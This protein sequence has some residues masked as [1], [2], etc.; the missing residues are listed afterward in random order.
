M[1][2]K[3][4][5]F[6]EK[7]NKKKI[8]KKSKITYIEELS[9]NIMD[10]SLDKTIVENNIL[11][12]LFCDEAVKLSRNM[13]LKQDFQLQRL[14]KILE[15]LDS[16]GVSGIEYKIS[17][18]LK[19]ELYKSIVNNH[20][21]T[22]GYWK[23]LFNRWQTMNA[24]PEYTH[25]GNIDRIID[26][27]MTD[28]N[29]I[30][31]LVTFKDFDEI[32]KTWLPEDVVTTELCIGDGYQAF[33]PI[34][35]EEREILTLTEESDLDLI[36][37]DIPPL[38]S[39]EMEAMI[40]NLFIE[41]R[42]STPLNIDQINLIQPDLHLIHTNSHLEYSADRMDTLNTFKNTLIYSMFTN[43]FTMRELANQL[44]LLFPNSHNNL[45]LPN[46]QFSIDLAV[47]LQHSLETQLNLIEKMLQMNNNQT[48]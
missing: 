31:F 16:K 17:A 8:K 27:R 44:N 5:H 4:T 46:I 13:H 10:A 24:F 41:E 23:K 11:A 20:K 40:N 25:H 3:L 48:C 45:I 19:D 28:E 39:F 34:F 47:E 1:F 21:N 43:D 15:E 37:P 33:V 22:V 12:I 18:F 6:K 2:W 35:P 32:Y 42:N 30:E 9:K 36:E 29:K 14:W 7:K 38:E 26:Q